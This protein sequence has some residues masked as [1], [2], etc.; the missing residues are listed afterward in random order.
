MSRLDPW[1]GPDQDILVEA[2][3]QI[4]RASFD[5]SEYPKS[6]RISRPMGQSHYQVSKT[7]LAG[8]LRQPNERQVVSRRMIA[9]IGHLTLGPD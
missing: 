7:L 8:T 2:R 5:L 3:T 1:S 4:A 6:F 9:K